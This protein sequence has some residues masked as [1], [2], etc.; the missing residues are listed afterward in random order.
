MKKSAFVNKLVFKIPLRIV[1]L[2]VAV[3]TAICVSLFLLLSRMTENSVKKEVEY[4]AIE[5]ANIA[6]KY[7]DNMQSQSKSLALA[8]SGYDNLDP[9]TSQAMI[10]DTLK[11]TLNDNRIFS[12][13]AAWE[14]NSYFPNTPDGASFY[15]FRDGSE[16][17]MDVLNDYETYNVGEY[18]A[19]S[20]STLKPHVTE[21]YSYTLTT[22]EVVWLISISNPIID[23]NGKFAGV[24]N[25]DILTD[26][27]NNLDYNMGGYKTA[28]SYILTNNGN[29]I[30]HSSDKS[31]SGTMYSE[32]GETTQNILKLA[33][34]GE[35][36]LFEDDNV[37]FGGKAYKIHVP[38]EIAGIE[39]NMSSAFV[40]NKDE[41]LNESTTILMFVII[42]S[43]LG[44][45]LLSVFTFLTLKRSLK[46]ID[47]IVSLARDMQEG[48]LNSD[49]RVNTNDE[50]GELSEI[51]R[52]TSSTLNEYITEISFI[53]N[54]IS[55]R[56]LAVNVE[57]DYVG[58]FAP[59]KESLISIVQSFNETFKL[60]GAS[61]EQVSASALEM[62]NGAQALSQGAT[63]QA[64]AIQEL[65]ASISDISSHIKQNADNVVIATE[66]VSETSSKINQSNQYMHD[67]LNAMSSINESS[68][69][70]SRIIK[71]I[72]D[73][74]FQT[75]ILA[76]NA[77]VEAARA[78]AA[79]KGFAV[80]AD[81]VRNLA[82]KS[83]DAARHTTALINN[84]I[85]NV[86]NGTTVANN[87]AKALESAASNS[88]LVEETINKVSVASQYQAE[89]IAQISVGIDQI[90]TVVQTNSATAEESAATSFELSR[91]SMTMRDEVAK[92]KLIKG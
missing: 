46:P 10:I 18:Y 37:I 23:K 30:A 61:A 81:E 43:A 80:V 59:I 14:P 5:N 72:D 62:S 90:S 83:A 8:F 45:V 76:L 91:Q 56:N 27:I 57:H 11:A 38:V 13:Y 84:S 74:A 60:I 28:Y 48:R 20:K 7:L 1:L 9:E 85:N 67:L 22:G 40:V 77:A 52:N 44:I 50:L 79:G 3:M 31:K 68:S 36:D 24:T 89:G 87:T 82:S 21:P 66:Y 88:Q 6:T 42:I 33:Q 55:D 19:V 41:A 58:D 92:F 26:T 29:Y 54:Q 17:K 35:R 4:I 70:I 16:I 25:C 69:E 49:I 12:C 34:N 78:G 73:I 65:S 2:I 39:E 32:K 63:E 53:L 71:V 86:H 47:S 75:N 51:F 64:S 15:A